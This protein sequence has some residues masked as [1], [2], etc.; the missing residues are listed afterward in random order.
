MKK[1]TIWT[2]IVLVIVLCAWAPWITESYSINKARD[3]F[4]HLGWAP[5]DN[6]C[7]PECGGCPTTFLGGIP[8]GALVHINY[9]CEHMFIGAGPIH[10]DTYYISFLGTSYKI[11]TAQ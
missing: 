2:I 4:N 6:P 9:G 10:R 7:D 8:F 5:E 11:N 3:H 1:S